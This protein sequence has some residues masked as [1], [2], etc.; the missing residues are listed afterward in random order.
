MDVKVTTEGSKTTLASPYHPDLPADARKLGGRFDRATKHWE[1]DSRD[2]QRVRDLARQYYGTDGTEP[3][4]DLVTVR[5]KLADYEGNKWDNTARFAGREIARRPGRDSEVRFASNVVLISGHLHPGGGSTQYPQINAGGDVVVE[6]RDL[7]RAA[8]EMENADKYEIVGEQG[9]DVDALLAERE[10][11]LA[12]LA[13]IDAQL[14]E[15]EGTQASTREA[16][17]ALGVSVR[18]VQRWA[19]AGKVEARKDDKGR[20]VI[21]ITVTP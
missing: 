18:T 7:P 14:P 1:F 2:E 17:A 20:W 9:P 21:T 12:R 8:L 11:L 15:P 6:V 13:E 10:R 4:G 19:A 16:A 3:D 5:V